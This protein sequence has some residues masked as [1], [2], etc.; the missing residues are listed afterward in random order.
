MREN[1]PG[2]ILTMYESMRE[3]D[4][5]TPLAPKMNTTWAGGP[6][7]IAQQTRLR[8]GILSSCSPGFKSQAHHPQF[9]ELIV[10]LYTLFVIAMPKGHK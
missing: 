1:A 9:F 4:S 6:T 3:R 10:K 8:L 7:S 2:E 5:L